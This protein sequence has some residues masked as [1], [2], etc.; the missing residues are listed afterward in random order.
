M[1]DT[2]IP[3]A[4]VE[5]YIAAY[6]LAVAAKLPPDDCTYVAKLAFDAQLAI[7]GEMFKRAV[8]QSGGSIKVA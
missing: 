2:T 5:A 7:E 4:C 6:K 3:V 1:T 8:Q